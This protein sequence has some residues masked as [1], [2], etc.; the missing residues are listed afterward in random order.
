[1][2]LCMSVYIGTKLCRYEKEVMNKKLERRCR[3]EESE[4]KM[5]DTRK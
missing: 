2:Y 4:G 5:K 1:M 3:E